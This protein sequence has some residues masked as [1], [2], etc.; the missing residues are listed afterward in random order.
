VTRIAVI[1]PSHD[2]GHLAE[3]AVASIRESEPVEIVVVDDATSDPGS[4]ERL[5]ALAATGVQVI[6]REQSGGPP[7][8]RMTGLAGTSAPFV[9]PLD[10]DDLLEPGVLGELADRLEANPSAAFV[11]GDYTL[12]GTYEGRYRS[13]SHFL[14]WT[15]TYVNPYPVASLFRRTALEQVGGWQGPYGYEDWDVWLGFAERGMTGIPAGRVI[16]RRRLHGDHRVLSGAR[17]RHGELYAELQRRHP[18]LFARRPELR[19]QE[20][21]APWKRLVY[22][23]LFG[24]RAV[25]PFAVEA[26]LQRTMMRLGLRL[27]S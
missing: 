18:E 6:R 12:F 1:I 13:P 27:S 5:E 9:F 23:V 26:F 21:P 4:L 11:W 19:E 2:D 20:R 14:P 17:R 24:R 25:V 22:P 8:A 16:Y 15:V 7:A 3:E 10:S